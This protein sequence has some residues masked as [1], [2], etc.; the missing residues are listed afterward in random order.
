MTVILTSACGF[1]AKGHALQYAEQTTVVC[2]SL[3]FVRIFVGVPSA[4][5]TAD[6]LIHK[7]D[8]FRNSD[9]RTDRDLLTILYV[10]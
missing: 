3:N 4:L 10:V 2:P 1:S 5:M 9:V 6:E 8:V 7:F